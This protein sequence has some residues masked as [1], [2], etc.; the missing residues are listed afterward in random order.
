MSFYLSLFTALTHTFSR[1]LA[2][3]AMATILTMR[4]VPFFLLVWII[5]NVSV[6]AL[7]IEVLPHIY[8]YGYAMPFY[9]VSKGVRNILFGTHNVLGYTFG[10]LIAWVLLSCVTIAVSQWFVHWRTNRVRPRPGPAEE[11]RSYSTEDAMER[12][13]EMEYA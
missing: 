9:N 4:F 5:T 10:V 7:P 3:E 11:K 6:A 2:L 12:A 1:G 8:R 13:L